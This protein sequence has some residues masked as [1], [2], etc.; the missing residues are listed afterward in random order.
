MADLTRYEFDG[1][2][3]KAHHLQ[4]RANGPARPK[5]RDD[6]RQGSVL[7]A[8]GIKYPL[9]HLLPPLMLK[10]DIDVRRF[11]AFLGNEAF[12]QCPSSKILGQ[13][14]S[15]NSGGFDLRLV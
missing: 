4:D 12:K 2:F 11:P 8:I 10:I 5:A 9:Q 15:Q 14:G 1:I 3:G 13:T 7:A 6:R